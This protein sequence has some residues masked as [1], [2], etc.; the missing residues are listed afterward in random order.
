MTEEQVK[1]QEKQR[2]LGVM[3]NF[4]V[5]YDSNVPPLTPRQKISIAFHGSTDPYA[6]VIAGILS[7]Y[8]QATDDHGPDYDVTVRN[9]SGMKV[10]VREEGYGMGVEGYAKRFGANYAD[11]F[12]GNIIGNAFLPILLK[13]DPRYFRVGS[14]P[15]RH[16]FLFA[17]EST[18]WCRR[19]SGTWGPNYANVLGNIAAGGI[20]NLYY[21]SYERGAGLTFERGLVVTAEG[22]V[23]AT[24]NEF[25]PD[26]TRHL[27]HREVSGKK[28]DTT[29]PTT[30]PALP[31]PP[32]P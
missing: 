13:E 2:T 12:D 7:L 16:R 8:G 3:P 14:G 32:Q 6:F 22:A 28:I 5:A 20:S 1:K 29:T 4:N 25:L 24:L 27:L 26:I 17:L 15:K 10:K 31:A 11:S 23:G 19:D 21:P 18:V 9:S 30:A